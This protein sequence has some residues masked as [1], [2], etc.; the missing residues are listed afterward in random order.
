MPGGASAP[1]GG[2]GAGGSF[3]VDEQDLATRIQ[4]VFN[5]F[6]RDGG[7][8]LDKIELTSVF[9]TL[10]PS[11]T[12]K[13]IQLFVK[14]LDRGGDGSVS[15][16]EFMAWIKA[17]SDE[18]QEF[19]KILL[20]ETGAAM[21]NRVR[22][23]FQRFDTDGGGYL[24][25]DELARVFGTLDSNFTIANID[26][27]VKE[28]DSGGDGRVSQREFMTW[29]KRGSDWAK[30]VTRAIARETGQAREE[31][32]RKAFD[33]YD[34]T[35][36]GSLDIEEL[37]KALKV[38]GSFSNDEV[39]KVCADLDKSKD[40]VISF[41]EFASWIKS[42]S[43]Q[44]EVQKAKSILAPSDSDGLEAVFYNFCGAG[45]ADMDSKSFKR[46]LTD[47]NLLD[48]NLDA[49]SV[50]LIFSETRVRARGQKNGIDFFQF[51]VALEFIAE[52]KGVS[53]AAIRTPILLQG[54]P[55]HS[56]AAHALDAPKFAIPGEGAHRAGKKHKRSASEKRID[57][58]LKAPLNE[59]EGQE[60]WRNTVDNSQLWKV[61]GLDSRAGRTLKRI[62][63]PVPMVAMPKKRSGGQLPGLGSPARPSSALSAS[64]SGVFLTRTVSL[65][66]IMSVG[67][68]R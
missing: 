14:Q 34:Y 55:K 31:R 61:F 11:F 22:E 26:A 17:G 58:I 53:K 41:Q 63:N 33:K 23:V 30:T 56:G 37:G 3:V 62:Y 20:K 59:V 15:H 19:F 48:K 51:E 50:D 24:D 42:G 57:A 36:D 6:D 60:T 43:G 39:K 38:L 52:K 1:E 65:P 66:Q 54:S 21:S 68:L 28:L 45:H 9:R 44:K 46:I 67:S 27:L 29:L 64:G 7:G 16:P 47:C 35:G 13:Q 4:D 10:S 2:A 12:A 32:I 49:T 25:P 8:L 40:G 18:A 5:R